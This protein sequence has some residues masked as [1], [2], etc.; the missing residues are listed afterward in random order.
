MHVGGKL[1]CTS[2]PRM[3]SFKRDIDASYLEYQV[4][5]DYP[6]ETTMRDPRQRDPRY[7]HS[8]FTGPKRA[9]T[10]SRCS[11]EMTRWTEMEKT[12]SVERKR[13]K[14]IPA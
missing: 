10:T 6:H 2:L 4:M 9:D 13:G 7:I 5:K 11:G 14:E 3:P 8:L 12:L 1:I